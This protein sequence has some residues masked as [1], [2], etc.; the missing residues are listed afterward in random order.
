MVYNIKPEVKNIKYWFHLVVIASIAVVS[1]NLFVAP[2][3]L[4]LMNVLKVTA[5][6][7]VA[8]II[9]H[10]LLRLD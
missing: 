10:T 7:G 5:I 2:L 9:A 6:V 8:D 4:T 3:Q 1:L